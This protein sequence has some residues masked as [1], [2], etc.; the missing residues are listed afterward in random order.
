MIQN[1]FVKPFDPSKGLEFG[2]YS[3]GE[4]VKDP[5]TNVRISPQQRL[6]EII[7]S[8]KLAEQAGIDV[9]DI[10]ESHQEY[11][12]SQAQ[13]VILGALVQATSSIKIASAATLVGLLD[14]VRVY[15]DFSTLD[16]LSN[17]RVE[18]VAGR[19]SRVGAFD[20]LG[21]S[22][23]DYDALFDEK[24]ALLQQLNR[25]EFV[26]WN[27]KFRAP[28]K[29]AHILP[30]PFSEHLPIWRAV[31][32]PAGSAIASGATGTPMVLAHLS[33]PAS[34]YK[35]T[36]DLFRHSAEQNGYD[37]ESLPVATGGFFY[38]GETTQKA[39]QEYYP[40]VNNGFQHTNGQTFPKE[41]FAQ[42][43]DKHSI[44]NV[45][46]ADEII[47]KLVYQHEMFNMQRYMAQLDLG[48]LPFEK[49]MKNIEII[50]SKILPEVKKRTA[51]KA[52]V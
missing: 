14:P 51:V 27:G 9:F 16:L 20:L 12:V 15:E 34:Y 49:I 23:T 19:A 29:N 42:A 44:I 46:S 17:G 28:L 18:L 8:A 2:I 52:S 25:E 35:R 4:H 32:G 38:V 21:Y 22:L 33:G 30:R 41:T 6:K 47:E 5:L 7:E 50:G 43:Y 26:T 31:G 45:G 36:I 40:Y 3:L 13:G 37:A 39:L 11:F 1:N 48:G 10:G 24:F